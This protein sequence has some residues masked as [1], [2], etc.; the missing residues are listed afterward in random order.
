MDPKNRIIVALD[1]NS[2]D[3]ALDLV[4]K[5]HEHVGCFKIGLEFITAALSQLVSV[6]RNTPAAIETLR[7]LRDLFDQLHGNVFWDGKFDD[8]PN[9]VA[10]ATKALAKLNVKMFN[11]HASAGVDAMIGAVANKGNALALAVTVLTAFE[12]ND[13]F[14]TFGAPS[15]ASVLQFARNAKLV[16]CDGIVCSPQELKLLGGRKE[17]RGLIKVT[18]GIRDRDDRR[19]DQNRTMTADE[20]ILAGA[21]YLVIGRQITTAPDPVAAAQKF[22]GEIAYG[23]SQKKA[24]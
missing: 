10:G 22:A 5:L 21:D 11:V 24:A 12:E 3:K 4:Q 18:P 13:A 16:G 19:D 14:L 6:S 20:A 7:Q 2:P 8:I 23:L 9:T 1:V 15:K 17:L